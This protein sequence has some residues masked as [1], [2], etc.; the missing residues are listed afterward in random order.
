MLTMKLT[1]LVTI[2]AVFITAI[3]GGIAGAMRGKHGV[4]APAMTGSLEFEKANRAHANTVE[5]LVLF[6]P[7]LWISTVALG[8]LWAA[9]VGLVWI[10]G[11]CLYA[12]LYMANTEKRIYGVIVTSLSTGVL[13]ISACVG[14]VMGFL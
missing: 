4:I 14:I 7:L 8:D 5:Q 1:A 13:A 3:L 12:W 2:G 11:R 6:L 10:F 9:S